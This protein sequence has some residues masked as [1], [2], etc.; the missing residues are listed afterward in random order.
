[1]LFKDQFV[2]DI[3]IDFG[4]D[5]FV[6]GSTIRYVGSIGLATKWLRILSLGGI[7]KIRNHLVTNPYSRFDRANSQLASC[8]SYVRVR[9]YG[10]A[11]D[12]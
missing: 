8:Y 6:D 5:R 3:F 10:A 11:W 7:D 9:I 12:S 1:M 2:K 4:G